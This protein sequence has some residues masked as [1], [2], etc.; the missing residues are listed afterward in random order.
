MP[1]QEGAGFETEMEVLML[2]S[3]YCIIFISDNIIMF[4]LTR[5]LAVTAGPNFV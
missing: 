3:I 4:K 1:S 5:P 2:A